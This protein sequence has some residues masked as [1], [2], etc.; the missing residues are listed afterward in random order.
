MNDDTF[1]RM[2]GLEN[3][4]HII[5]PSIQEKKF[6]ILNIFSLSS[7]LYLIVTH[8]HCSA[9]Q[10]GTLGLHTFYLC[11]STNLLQ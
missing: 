2:E 7:T 10:R 11:K 6:K 8:V 4:N 1:K 3:L 9:V 5:N